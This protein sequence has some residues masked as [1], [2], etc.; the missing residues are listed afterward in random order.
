MQVAC[1][2]RVLFH[3]ERMGNRN[4]VKHIILLITPL[5]DQFSNSFKH[6]KPNTAEN[7]V[8]AFA[9]NQPT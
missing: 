7:V 4:S 6:A 8:Q 1:H 9:W 5:T 2:R 3:Q